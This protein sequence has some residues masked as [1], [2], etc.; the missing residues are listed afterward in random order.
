VQF[1]YRYK[2]SATLLHL[3]CNFPKEFNNI[4]VILK[5]EIKEENLQYGMSSLHAWIRF[6]ECLIKL[7]YRVKIKK[8]QA[9]SDDD[10]EAVNTRKKNRTRGL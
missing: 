2:S 7:S 1:G 10:K 6:F 4:D 8:W 3:S 9:R 5:K